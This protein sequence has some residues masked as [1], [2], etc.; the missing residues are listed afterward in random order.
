MNYE[1][2]KFD[3]ELVIKDERIKIAIRDEDNDIIAVAKF[4]VKDLTSYNKI[5]NFFTDL[6]DIYKI[7]KGLDKKEIKVPQAIKDAKELNNLKDEEIDEFFS[8]MDDIFVA[9]D[10]FTDELKEK[11]KSLIKNLDDVFGEEIC[12]A[13]LGDGYNFEKIV[14]L[15]QIA[16]PYFQKERE[17]K[18]NPYLKSSNQGVME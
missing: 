3:N 4:D 18:I 11:I 1:N 9:I 8:E 17:N 15:I 5:C 6:K 10:D 7:G 13:I 14:P 12:K 16:I 2:M